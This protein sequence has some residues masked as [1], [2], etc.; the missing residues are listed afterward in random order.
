MVNEMWEFTAAS[1]YI[2]GVLIQTESHEKNY[3]GHVTQIHACSLAQEDV[4]RF[5][6]SM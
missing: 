5:S 1:R 4:C 3:H 2:Q 6:E